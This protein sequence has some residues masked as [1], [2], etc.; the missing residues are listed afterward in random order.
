MPGLDE[1]LIFDVGAHRGDD[2]DF[3]LGKGFKVIAVEANPTL[4]DHLRK[5]F[6]AE[7]DADRLVLVDRV[8]GPDLGET[9]AFYINDAKD[10]WSAT[11]ELTASKGTMPVRRVEVRTCSLA[12]LFQQFGTPYYL[13]VDIEM[14]DLPLS[15][16]LLRTPALPQYVSFEFHETRLA[17]VL[18]AAG[19]GSY[20]IIN[21]SLNG[22]K[23]PVLPPREGT[24]YFPAGGFT[25]THSGFFGR[26]LP[27]TEWLPFDEVMKLRS[28]FD[29]VT[30]FGE[31]KGCWFDL[32]ARLA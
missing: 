13:K 11:D 5:R 26:D 7:L 28:A 6:P 18:E 17:A 10:D 31:F 32:H 30:R 27:D 8:V 16:E 23:E 25:G 1:N 22:L 29:V 20:Q 4:V 9:V 14:G 24:E 3:Y 21:Q 15:T 12:D 19:Y 2:T